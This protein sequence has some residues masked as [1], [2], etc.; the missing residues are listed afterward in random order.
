VCGCCIAFSPGGR[1]LA[2]AHAPDGTVR[3]WSVADERLLHEARGAELL[4]SNVLYGAAF[5]PDGRRYAVGGDRALRVF[6][7]PA[8]R[9]CRRWDLGADLFTVSFAPDSRRLAYYALGCPDIVVA[10]LQPGVA[11]I[12]FPVGKPSDGS[13]AA[14]IHPIAWHP[15]GR[16]LGTGLGQDHAAVVWDVTERREVVRF[17]GHESFVAG[18]AFHP[19]GEL[20]L[21][22]SNDGTTRLWSVVTGRQILRFSG[23]VGLLGF[24]RQGRFRG[25]MR[26]GDGAR[27]VEVEPSPVCRAVGQ[28]WKRVVDTGLCLGG[29]VA[30]AL[31][32]EGVSFWDI[33][34]GRLLASVAV[35]LDD[36]E[37]GAAFDPTGRGFVVESRGSF[38]FWPMTRPSGGKVVVG[39]PR[40]LPLPKSAS[41]GLAFTPDGRRLLHG[42][43]R[44]LDLDTDRVRQAF[45]RFAVA[46]TVAVSPD[47]RLAAVSGWYCDE[48]RVLDLRAE[49][50][51]RTFPVAGQYGV[52]LWFTSDGGHLIMGQREGYTFRDVRTWEQTRHLPR[53]GGSS[54]GPLAFSPDG[55]LLA[56]ELAPDVLSL[57]DTGTWAVLARLQLP[58]PTR[59][60]FHRALHFTPDGTRLV[61]RAVEPGGLLVW[62]LDR[63]RR[64]LAAV[65]LDWDYPPFPPPMPA[66]RDRP[67]I[68]VVGE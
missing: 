33:E 37:W 2:A 26:W 52:G 1:F 67:E 63:L 48:V 29:R 64:E 58:Y 28:P 61:L 12:T 15:H 24:D 11:P 7:L 6:D 27:R 31:T 62:D 22:D 66:G 47:G 32:R 8:F 5:S 54:A 4:R 36:G 20:A 38:V 43:G 13:V 65:G 3:L 19:D 60:H 51:V 56:V 59:A 30:Y 16:L 18:L 55:R 68:V 9:E 21:S 40:H 44:L 17:S 50:V 25:G 46:S 53:A 35:P 10:S 34:D 23:G 42:F 57:L 41:C 14:S 39:P 49:K 45:P